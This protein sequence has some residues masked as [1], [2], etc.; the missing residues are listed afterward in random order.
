MGM[1]AQGKRRV[2]PVVLAPRAPL[3]LERNCHHCLGD[4]GLVTPGSGQ[5]GVLQSQTLGQEEKR[6]LVHPP[7]PH[8]Q[9][10]ESPRGLGLGGWQQVVLGVVQ[11][12]WSQRWYGW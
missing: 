7:S 6:S 2:V 4:L 11:T 10:A 9:G 12:G 5:A 8:L 1:A 3:N